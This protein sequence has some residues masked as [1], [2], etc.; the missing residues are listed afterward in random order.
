MPPQEIA[1]NV[2]VSLHYKLRLDDGSLVEETE[3]D[4]PL[5]YLHGHD[6]IIAGLERELEGLRVGDQKKV[7][8]E[9]DDG[10]GEYDPDDVE[11]INLADLPP[12]LALEVGMLLAVEDEAGN[13]MVAE[14]AEIGDETV[15]LDFNHPMAGEMLAFEVTITD[16]RDATEEELAHGH[17]H[18]DDHHH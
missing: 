10:Y 3:A 17:V 11:E 6:N 2:V 12:D 8:V 18:D 13:E 1:K 4:D 7:V 16:L 15:T 14:V 5:V 9:P